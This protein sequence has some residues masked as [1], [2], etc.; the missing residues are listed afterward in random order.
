MKAF[1]RTKIDIILL[2]N[3][4]KFIILKFAFCF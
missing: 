2:E 4:S 3:I 1:I